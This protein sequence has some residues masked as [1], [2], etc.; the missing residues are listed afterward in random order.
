MTRLLPAGDADFAWLLGETP[1]PTRSGLT[2][3]PGGVDDPAVLALLRTMTARVLAAHDRGSWLVVDGN[4][5]VGLCSYKRPPAADGGVEIGYG[6][7][8]SR[9]G[10]G[11]ATGAARL[12]IEE[13]K[14]DPAVRILLAETAVDNLASQAV[15]RKCGFADIGRGI[16]AEDGEVMLW[17]LELG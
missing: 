13:A 4:E 1:A 8:E 9:R 11:H 6:I 15:L 7:A 12:L 5:V 10:R 3:P 14:A 16:D 2:L 17:R